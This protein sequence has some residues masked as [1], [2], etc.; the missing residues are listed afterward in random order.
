MAKKKNTQAKQIK[1]EHTPKNTTK[2]VASPPILELSSQWLLGITLILAGLYFLYSRSANGFYQQD[3]AAHFVSMKG[4]WHNPNSVLSNWA[5]PGYKIL[6]ALPS[7][8]GVDFV[9]F[10]NCLV[11]AFTCFF[12]Y[13][14]AKLLDSK[15]PILAFVLTATQPLWINLAFRN[16]SELITALLLS[17]SL[18]FHLRNKFVWA[19]LIVSYI[20]FI[21]QEF[22]PI[23]GL[24]FIY[25]LLNK[26]FLAAVLLSVFPIFQ[27]IWGMTLTGDPLYLLNQMLG[28]SEQIAGQYPRKGF[29][30]YF[31]MSITIFG[32]V[33]VTLW[34]AYLWTWLLERISN[35]RNKI[36]FIDGLRDKGNLIL[37]VSLMY[38][39]MNCIFN[40]QTLQIGPATGGNLRY[41]LII[42]PLVAI[43]G[44]LQVEKFKTSQYKPQLLI[45]I[46]IYALL[47]AI[48]MTH[49]HNF[50]IFNE[51]ER[52]WLP[53]VG[54]IAS[55]FIM[56]LPLLLRQDMMGLSI[57]A[58]LM[59]LLTVRPIK[60]SAEDEAC[61]NLAKWYKQYESTSGE[62]PQLFVHHEMFYYYLGRTPYDFKIKPKPIEDKFLKDAP[63]GS[64]II[65]DSHYS[66]RPK[67]RPES[68]WFNYFTEKE[69]EYQALTQIES[70][71]PKLPFGI[72]VF[73]KN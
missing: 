2:M 28:T 61:K 66:Y 52:D 72:L 60:L 42:S 19:S 30:H 11:S 70:D 50:V 32:S 26:Q 8:L 45:L 36:G 29:M 12:A 1:V 69:N 35:W 44:T 58:L 9:I 5:K 68:L 67:M 41:L 18:Y 53:L 22:Y 4:F 23:L 25:L 56:I 16:Y 40:S 57:I 43:L 59:V 63:K 71:D 15:I 33:A 6:Y 38:F 49:P 27:Q 55:I 62:P 21:R 13:K 20:A 14:I 37:A 3:E 46:S 47:V 51:E 48:F 7:L 24:Y 10:I 34:V 17:I 39:L 31:K 73:I 64:L 65:W 54:V